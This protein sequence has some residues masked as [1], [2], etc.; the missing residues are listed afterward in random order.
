MI[1]QLIIARQLVEDL[2]SKVARLEH[3]RNEYRNSWYEM[4]AREVPPDV[5][6]RD[7]QA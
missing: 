3:Q 4:F 5:I 1:G 7:E 6:A 2:V